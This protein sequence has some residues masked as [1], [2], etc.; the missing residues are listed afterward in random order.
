MVV[1][2]MIRT[3]RT[4]LPLYQIVAADSRSP[5]N[6]KFLKKLGNYNPKTSP[7]LSN[8]DLEEI[9]SWVGKGAQLTDTVRT[10]FKQE[11]VKL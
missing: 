1:I 9:K 8:L 2:R 6:G 11:S 5:R 7:M 3:G 10:I 4:N